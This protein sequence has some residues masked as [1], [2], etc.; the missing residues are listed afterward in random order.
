[1]PIARIIHIFRVAL[2]SPLTQPVSPVAPFSSPRII[3]SFDGSRRRSVYAYR[4]IQPRQS[5]TCATSTFDR[6]LA[7]PVPVMLSFP[8]DTFSLLAR[9]I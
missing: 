5:G 2:S 6:L 8:C 1:M 3:V 9:A 7:H 4:S